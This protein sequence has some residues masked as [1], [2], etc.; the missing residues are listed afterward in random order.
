[1][2]T[3]LEGESMYIPTNAAGSF[4]PGLERFGYREALAEVIAEL[5]QA[6]VSRHDHPDRRGS[7]TAS[8]KTSNLPR[9][10]SA[11]RASER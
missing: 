6:A 3:D 7:Q 11:P 1:L 5:G 9:A 4:A 8:S 10:R 2:N